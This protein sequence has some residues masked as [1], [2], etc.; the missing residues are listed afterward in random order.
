[1]P[2]F[3]K[4][5][6]FLESFKTMWKVSHN[7]WRVLFVIGG[8]LILNI[9]SFFPFNPASSLESIPPFVIGC[10]IIYLCYRNGA[11]R[12]RN[13]GMETSIPDP[14]VEKQT[15]EKQIFQIA[16][17]K[18]GKLTI[19]DVVVE[20]DCSIE[21]AKES[22]DKLAQKGYVQIEVADNGIMVYIF[23]EIKERDSI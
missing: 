23:P 8:L 21:K 4:I 1:M 13:L 15:L 17:K 2:K 7:G 22:L 16:I 3:N 5:K 11:K 19:A 10:G 12:L 20:A 18:Q 9:F 6:A 14:I